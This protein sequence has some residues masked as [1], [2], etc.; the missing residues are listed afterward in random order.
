MFTNLTGHFLLQ[1]TFKCTG[2]LFL[3]VLFNL[4]G[5]SSISLNLGHCSDSTKI[6]STKSS[7][8]SVDFTNLHLFGSFHPNSF[9][10]S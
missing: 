8:N 1:F 5:F 4:R 6:N 10:F 7:G 3:C 9:Q 2:S